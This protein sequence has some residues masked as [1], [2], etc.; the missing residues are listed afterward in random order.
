MIGELRILRP[1]YT[2][3]LISLFFERPEREDALI[4]ELW[5]AGTAGIAEEDG[6]L[7]AFFDS[8]DEAELLRRFGEWTPSIRREEQIDWERVSRDAWPPI[9]AGERVFLGAP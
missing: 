4:G 7:R 6:G 8:P 5:E 1:N 2:V 3:D 9:M